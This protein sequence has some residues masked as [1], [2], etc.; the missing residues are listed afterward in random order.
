[1]S[2]EPT[3]RPAQPTLGPPERPASFYESRPAML[4]RHDYTHD[5]SAGQVW[6]NDGS[7]VRVGRSQPFPD[8]A[9]DAGAGL[10]Q[11]PTFRT[12]PGSWVD[13]IVDR[14]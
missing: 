3:V 12:P 13:P 2:H 7:H 6:R 10:P 8:G 1:M 4:R 14:G 5:Q 11:R 9:H